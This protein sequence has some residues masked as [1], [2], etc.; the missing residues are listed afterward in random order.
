MLLPT[1]VDATTNE[2]HSAARQIDNDDHVHRPQRLRRLTGVGEDPWDR[3]IRRRMESPR[4]T[5]TSPSSG[6]GIDLDPS[7]PR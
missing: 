7:S 4:L 5:R 6:R 2:V 3:R 1:R